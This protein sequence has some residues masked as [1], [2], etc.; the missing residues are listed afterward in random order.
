MKRFFTFKKSSEK[1]AAHE[2]TN[3]SEGGSGHSNATGDNNSMPREQAERSLQ[4]SKSV[5][6]DPK[7]DLQ[8]QELCEE[9][10]KSSKKQRKKSKKKRREAEEDEEAE[11]S[12]R[13][14]QEMA[15]I[16]EVKEG[17]VEKAAS[18]APKAEIPKA[19]KK[20]VKQLKLLYES[21]INNQM[22]TV[23]TLLKNRQININMP[24]P[25]E[26]TLGE[27][28]SSV[29]IH[30]DLQ[31]QPT[32]ENI[33][34]AVDIAFELYCY[35][36]NNNLK[37]IVDLTKLLDLLIE[38]NSQSSLSLLLAPRN[39]SSSVELAKL[40]YLDNQTKFTK[41]LMTVIVQKRNQRE[42]NAMD[43][44]RKL[45]EMMN[46][47]EKTLILTESHRDSLQSH[48]N[49]TQLR[50]ENVVIHQSRVEEIGS[51]IA[52]LREKELKVRKK[53]VLL[54]KSTILADFQQGEDEFSKRF[55]QLQLNYDQWQEAQQFLHKQTAKLK[56]ANVKF[57]KAQNELEKF[58]RR[59]AEFIQKN[60]DSDRKVAELEQQ[61]RETKRRITQLQ[62]QIYSIKETT[63]QM[64]LVVF[65]IEGKNVDF[66]YGRAPWGVSNI[67]LRFFRL[68]TFAPTASNNSTSSIEPTG[69]NNPYEQR[70]NSAAV[71]EKNSMF[72]TA[73]RSNKQAGNPVWNN[74]SISLYELCLGEAARPFKI[75][76]W[77]ALRT[78]RTN[79]FSRNS[80][81]NHNIQEEEGGAQEGDRFVDPSGTYE[82]I[83]SVCTSVRQLELNSGHLEMGILNPATA[84]N[85][86]RYSNRGFLAFTSFKIQ[87][88]AFIGPN[89]IVI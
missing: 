14:R 64:K 18:F 70:D 84:A 72:Q 26:I 78:S 17:I 79:R 54:Q 31:L 11:S 39:F 55:I 77:D 34:T 61:L 36:E 41:L 33:Y 86:S 38:Y 44:H 5:I 24:I 27:D 6:S 75:E 59:K 40:Q 58:Q 47:A 21:I 82:L 89:G 69:S 2:K 9:P 32:E 83:G 66:I 10:P 68:I 1:A 23:D 12:P 28:A 19:T 71:W 4:G 76:V 15:E 25:Y 43:M 53:A 80:A 35:Y 37:P 74:L 63:A 3:K 50:K 7:N 30:A 22:E 85:N 45:R 51:D 16:D 60:E 49:S 87:D 57:E 8:P 67:F 52:A 62:A 42:Q 48:R 20:Q 29:P 46:L 81:A 65:S 13:S 73:V 56:Q 88:N